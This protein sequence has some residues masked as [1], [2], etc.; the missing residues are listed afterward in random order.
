MA[1]AH[2]R[3]HGFELS[4]ALSASPALASAAAATVAAAATATAAGPTAP[5]AV[6]GVCGRRTVGRPTAGRRGLGGDGRAG[7]EAV[8]F[9]HTTV[10]TDSAA[11][12]GLLGTG[13]AIF[14]VSAAID[15]AIAAGAGEPP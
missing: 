3:P 4:V 14:T 6:A 9:S 10:C 7:C 13:G 11:T 12:S 2:D 15:T 1:S 8:P 5:G